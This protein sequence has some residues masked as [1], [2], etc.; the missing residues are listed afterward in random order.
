MCNVLIILYNNSQLC[1]AILKKS[2]KKA[3]NNFSEANMFFPNFTLCV[4]VVV[5]NF[6]LYEH[7]LLVQLKLSIYSRN[8]YLSHTLFYTDVNHCFFDNH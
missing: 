5:L 7:Y 4:T 1:F 3:L 6:T 2:P 8:N